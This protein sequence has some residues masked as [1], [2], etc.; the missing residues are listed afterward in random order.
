MYRSTAPA[1]ALLAALACGEQRT[2]PNTAQGAIA[3]GDSAGAAAAAAAAPPSDDAVVT[4][5]AAAAGDRAP[6]EVGRIPVLEY[7]LIGEGPEKHWKVSPARFRENLETLY[8]RGYRPVNMTDLVDKKLDLPAGLSPVV[9]V[10]DDASPEQFRYVERDGQLQVDPTSALGMMLAFN[11]KHPDWS[12]KGVFCMLPAASHGHAFF[13]DKGVQ[14]QKTEWR[15]KKVQFLKEKG[16]ELCNH[17]LYHANLGKQTDAR[18]QEFIARGDMAIDSAVPGYKVRTFALPLGVWPKNRP[19][20]W[21]G[22]WTDP[23]TGRTVRYSYD[24]VLE[25]AGSPT[26]SPHDPQ[27]NPRSIKRIEVF[28][29]ELEKTLDQLDRGGARYVSDGNPRTVARPT[30]TVATK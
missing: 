14:G 8:A 22:S 26:R 13:G 16:F 30:K 28:A 9:L 6:N 3:P 2:V 21:A 15:F 24:A 23:K 7:H 20:A 29:R 17:T 4:V 19:V 12:N 11:K 25:V 5:P 18:A 1:L 27:F 10:F